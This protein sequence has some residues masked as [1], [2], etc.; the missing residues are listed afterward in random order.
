MEKKIHQA[1]K[2]FLLACKKDLE[3]QLQEESDIETL[4]RIISLSSDQKDH[5]KL[6]L[7]SDRLSLQAK[8]ALEIALNRFTFPAGQNIRID[9]QRLKAIKAPVPLPATPSPA[10]KKKAIPNVAKV[11]L[12]ASGKGGVGKSTISTNLAIS[13]Q[14]SGLRVGI[15]DADIYGPSIPIMLGI[16]QNKHLVTADGK[17]EPSIAHNLAV[18]SFGL[19]ADPRR[20]VV[21]RGPLLASTLLR[22]CYDTAW[23]VLDILIMDLPPGTGDV[24]LSLAETVEV[25]GAIVVTT[26]QDVALADAHKAITM[27]ENHD[28]NLLGLVANMSLIHC[29]K[30][31][32]SNELWGERGVVRAAE[33]RQ[34]PLLASVP[35]SRDI[36][37]QCDSGIPVALGEDRIAEKFDNLAMK[38][39][40]ELEQGHHAAPEEGA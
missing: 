8:L 12:V 15:L 20:A 36:I 28:I 25:S 16:T 34:L 30:C 11:I 14:K 17:I 32:H 21:W 22:L 13:L 38:V 4:A 40:A 27:F 6:V 23:P 5:W 31:D 10:S 37:S 18:V 33:Q 3:C 19:I 39:I 35:L 26:G 7:A 1:L 24:Q 9:F 2:D 29:E